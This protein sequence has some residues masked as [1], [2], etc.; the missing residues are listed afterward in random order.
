MRERRVS[1]TEVHRGDAELRELRDVGPAEFGGDFDPEV[2]DERRSGR[3]RQAW[4]GGGGRVDD[5]DVEPLEH[6][7]DVIGGLV[8][9]SVGREAEVDRDG[10]RVG[11]DI[12]GD[13]PA[14]ADGVESL[15]VF[16]PVDLHP[17]R[18]VLVQPRQDLA[19]GVDCVLPHPG[20]G[21]VC[22]DAAGHHLGAQCPLTAGFDPAARRLHQDREVGRQQLGTLT[23]DPTKS[24]VNV[25][26]LL[27]LIEHERD[28]PPGGRGAHGQPQADRNAAL[29][30][31]AAEAPQLI[32]YQARREVVVG[33]DGVEMTGDD[34][35]LVAAELGPSNERVAVALNGEVSAAGQGRA[36]GV[37]NQLLVPALRRD[38]D[39][40]SR[41][42]DN[43]TGKVEAHATTLPW[44]AERLRHGRYRVAMENAQPDSG[45]PGAHAWGVATVTL[46]GT[47][48][49]AWYPQPLLGAVPERGLHE[50]DE[51]TA[52]S[53]DDPIR[54]VR[55]I[56][57]RTAIEDL[58]EPPADAYDVYLRLHLM[59]HR[60]VRPH[61][62]NLTGIFGL[63]SNVVWTS[64]GPCAVPD[65]EHVRARAR[66]A[67][68]VV[69]VTSIDKFPRMTDYV[70]PAG[71]RIADADR[72]RLGAHLAEGTTVMHEGFV[73]FNAGTLGT[74]MVE[75]RISAGVVVGDG[76]DIGG[77]A[78]IM[79]TLSGG[80]TE[81]IS[82]GEN[83]LLGANS[84]I[85][86]SLGNDC[87]V[88]AGTYVTAGSRVTLPDG[89]VVKA[90]E[91]SGQDGLLFLLNSETGALEARPRGERVGIELNADLHAN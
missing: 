7:P 50:P 53:G 45:H 42:G 33:R 90:A 87:V 76:S 60:L 16:E 39:E 62:I 68:K 26:D 91:L 78:S 12:A 40:I 43:V 85:G 5:P 20:A 77:G 17:S 69:T 58:Q 2:R 34:H 44:L 75:G 59:S 23:C 52:M 67:G 3:K 86:I 18:L 79:G 48:L 14:D 24:V 81:V 8:L 13:S 36:H 37:A 19:G 80:G 47:V 4:P 71:V 84:G 31:A 54:Q 46:D 30:V 38:V 57:I 10:G 88:A 11:N 25:L 27:A 83:S 56:V 63:L 35:A 22:T 82:V 55:T 51:L 73:N 49:D 15:A 70:V 29:H 89:R 21:G 41:Q 64:I 74:A 61:G 6:L 1:G 65:F 32:A 66:A 72:V 28:V 9:G